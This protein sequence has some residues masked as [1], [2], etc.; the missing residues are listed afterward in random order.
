MAAD[1]Q[2]LPFSKS[3]DPPLQ[4]H[5]ILQLRQIFSNKNEKTGSRDGFI[6]EAVKVF[7][8]RSPNFSHVTSDMTSMTRQDIARHVKSMCS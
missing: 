4:I 2:C 8:K 1:I 5:Q 7:Y 3:L 6:Q